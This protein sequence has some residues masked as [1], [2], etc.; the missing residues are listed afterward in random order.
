LV[1]I[2]DEGGDQFLK[3]LISNVSLLVPEQSLTG[4]MNSTLILIPH[5]LIVIVD[6]LIHELYLG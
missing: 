4:Q 2:L 6:G 3:L 1:G 5:F